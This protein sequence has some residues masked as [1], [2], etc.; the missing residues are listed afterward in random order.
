MEIWDQFEEILSLQELPVDGEGASDD[1]EAAAGGYV[2][3]GDLGWCRF[4]K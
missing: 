3:W 1:A 4:T 2:I